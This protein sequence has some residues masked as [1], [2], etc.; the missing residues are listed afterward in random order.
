MQGMPKQVAVVGASAEGQALARAAATAGFDVILID[1]QQESLDKALKAID[2][3]LRKEGRAAG[4]MRIS[5]HTAM[6]KASG[7]E[8]VIEA[9][10]EDREEKKKTLAEIEAAAD[11][12]IASAT[13]TLSITDLAGSAARPENVIGL[14][15]PT[16]WSRVA[17]LA[18]GL[19]TSEETFKKTRALAIALGLTPVNVHD[20]PGRVSTRLLMAAINDSANMLAGGV[21]TRDDI[22]AVTRE[23]LGF[24]VFE[25][26]D[27]LGLDYCLDCLESLR[28]Q[29]QD[30]RFEPSKAIRDLAWPNRKGIP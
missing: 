29:T 26:A 4:V 12:I 24:P 19:Q 3:E 22:N 25:L 8:F 11:C 23:T 7:S 18:R 1:K 5:C 16:P 2:A 10:R 27:R 21:A 15:L 13:S 17:E 9:V 14:H 6:A 30:P 20:E 28:N